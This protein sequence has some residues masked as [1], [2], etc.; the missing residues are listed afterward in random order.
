MSFWSLEKKICS[1]W[2]KHKRLS[3]RGYFNLWVKFLKNNSWFLHKLFHEKVCNIIS[4]QWQ[5]TDPLLIIFQATRLLTKTIKCND[6]LSKVWIKGYVKDYQNL[7]FA[8]PDSVN[9]QNQHSPLYRDWLESSIL[10][11]KNSWCVNW[12]NWLYDQR[13]AGR[14]CCTWWDE[15]WTRSSFT[16]LP[17]F[18]WFRNSGASGERECAF[19]LISALAV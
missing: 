6:N 3:F 1:C 12:Q 15:R 9:L 4:L 8:L 16:K 2:D 11:Q 10:N 14:G 17:L 18:C 5:L 13:D 19:N 7:F